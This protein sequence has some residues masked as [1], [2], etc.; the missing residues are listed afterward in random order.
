MITVSTIVLPHPNPPLVR[1]WD[2]ILLFWCVR[3]VT[4]SSFPIP[5][6]L[7]PVTCYL[8][9]VTCYPFLIP[10]SL[11]PVT[12]YLLPIPHSSFPVPCSLFPVPCSLFPNIKI[13]CLILSKQ[14]LRESLKKLL[15]FIDCVDN[16]RGCFFYFG[17]GGKFT[18]TNS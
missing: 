12:C 13:T 15:N 16:Q 14:P 6:S 9:P 5:H 1:G 10:H 8:L 3:C 17:F 11:L 4:H 2:W 7:L 18:N